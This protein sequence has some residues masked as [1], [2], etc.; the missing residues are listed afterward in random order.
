MLGHRPRLVLLGQKRVSLSLAYKSR[1][2]D[3]L[4]GEWFRRV[5]RQPS[6]RREQFLVRSVIVVRAAQHG[7]HALEAA[8]TLWQ[9]K[10][11]VQRLQRARCFVLA[12][13]SEPP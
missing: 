3:G 5:G 13:R 11:P 2:G 12:H 9:G 4:S 6:P 8:R 1:L 10:M 7:V